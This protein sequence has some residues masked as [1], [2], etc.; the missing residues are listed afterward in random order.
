MFYNSIA[1]NSLYKVVRPLCAV[2]F[3]LFTS[4]FLFFVQ[5]E[6]LARAQFVFS[7]GVTSYSLWWGAVIIPLVLQLLQW[8]VARIVTM[9]VRFYALTYFPSVLCLAMLSSLTEEAMRDFSFFSWQWIAPV[10][11]VIYIV[12]CY[13]VC[14]LTEAFSRENSLML[15]DVLWPNAFIMLAM[16]IFCGSVSNSND[17]YHYELKV[18][19]L[20]LERQYEK[21]LSVADREY[22]ASQHLTQ[23]RMYALSRQGQLGERLFDYPQYYGGDGLIDILDNDTT[24]R[25]PNRDIYLHLG[26]APDTNTVR[27]V[28][29]FF[30]LV[31]TDDSLSNQRTIDYELS[32]HLLQRDLKGFTKLL[33]QYYA[34]DA[35]LPRAFAEATLYVQMHDSLALPAYSIDEDTRGRYW[36][37]EAR[38]QEITDPVERVNRTRREYGHTFWWYYENETKQPN[39]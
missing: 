10:L 11:L 18:E 32:C 4:F 35:V 26:V 30:A 12:L 5:G 7:H 23:L 24:R 17:V 6:V 2:L 29:H 9:P 27:S 28:T 25:L 14:R 8:V 36:Q 20:M 22:V 3:V 1:N 15:S 37:Y 19:R 39:Y 31:N 16:I 21:A 33:S 34:A 38:K 13:I